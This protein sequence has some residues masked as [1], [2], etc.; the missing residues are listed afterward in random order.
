[1]NEEQGILDE[2]LAK[3]TTGVSFTT[4]KHQDY[5]GGN[6]QAMTAKNPK[7]GR[8]RGTSPEGKAIGALS[9]HQSK[10]WDAEAKGDH[11]SARKHED[12]RKSQAFKIYQK[13]GR[14]VDRADND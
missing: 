13:S 2:K 11:K 6:N 1:M 8:Q 12:R 7:T 4:G 10:Q 9:R 3:G 5:K 14:I